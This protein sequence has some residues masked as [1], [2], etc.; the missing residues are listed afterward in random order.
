MTRKRGPAFNEDY[1]KQGSPATS[2]V[3]IENMRRTE[4]TSGAVVIGATGI[5]TSVAIPIQAGDVITNITFRSGATAA[6][7]PTHWG[8]GLYSAAAALL[9]QTADQT[10]TAWAANTTKTLA[11][12]TPQLITVP[13]LYYAA[14]W[15][16]ATTQ[17]SCSGAILAHLDLSTGLMTT[18]KVLAQSSG[19][20][21]T[22]TLPATIATP[23]SLIGVPYVVLT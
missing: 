23:T 9:A 19:S 5:M 17:I 1:L 15:M 2:A 14:I 8:F 3:Y 20:G 21:L 12:A 10:T 4:V 22:T 11:L 6:S 13:G 18:E 16:T 7:V